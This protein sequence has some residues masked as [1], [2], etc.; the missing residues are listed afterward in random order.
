METDL[1]PLAISMMELPVVIVDVWKLVTIVTK[2][3]IVDFAAGVL[4]PPTDTYY[5][6]SIS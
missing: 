5:I 6:Y 2:I 1:G 4:D 3:S